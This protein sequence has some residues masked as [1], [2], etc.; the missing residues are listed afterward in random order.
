ME[1]T[2]KVGDNT[3]KIRVEGRIPQCYKC[4]MK[5]SVINVTLL[6]VDCPPE[7]DEDKDGDKVVC[8]LLPTEVVERKY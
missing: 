7:K 6:R 2:I 3:L 8:V 5:A 1:E 4:D